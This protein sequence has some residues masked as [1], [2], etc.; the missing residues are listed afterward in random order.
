MTFAP[1]GNGLI[2]DLVM[3]LMSQFSARVHTGNL[4]TS[5]GGLLL[6]CLASLSLVSGAGGESFVT[7]QCACQHS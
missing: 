4:K 2:W 6:M 5:L 7:R 3:L 1:A